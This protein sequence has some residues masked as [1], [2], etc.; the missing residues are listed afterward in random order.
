CGVSIT[1]EEVRPFAHAEAL[2]RR[3][4]AEL[5]VQSGRA[6]SVREAFARYLGEGGPVALRKVLLPVAQAI[7]LVRGAGG[8]AAWAHPSYD[9]TGKTLA[10][11][12]SYGLGGVEAAYPSFRPGR[13]AELRS[14]ADSL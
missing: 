4:L 2:G 14:L 7:G 3:H 1:D 8:V 13:V 9:C 6:G 11:L 10:E 12:R 5:L